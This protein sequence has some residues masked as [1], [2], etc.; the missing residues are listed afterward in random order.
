MA[1][2]NL[3]PEFLA[4]YRV[5]LEKTRRAAAHVGD[6]VLLAAVEAAIANLP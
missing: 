3:P 5:I 4:D 1:L 2:D 6:E